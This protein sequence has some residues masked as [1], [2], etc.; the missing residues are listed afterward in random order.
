MAEQDRGAFR[1]PSPWLAALALA[2]TAAAAGALAG[3]LGFVQLL[4]SR[5]LDLRFR[6]RGPVAPPPEILIVGVDEASFET[7]RMRYPF[8]P[9]VYAR[10]VET[11]SRAGA[12]AVAFD[13]LYS[14]PSRECDP[15]GQDALLA[16]SLRKAG[17]VVW[18][19]QL[20]DGGAAQEPIAVIRD[21][22]AGT[23]FINLPDERDSRIRRFQPEKDGRPCFAAAVLEAY[24]GFRPPSATG[25]RLRI[26]NFHGGRSS[27]PTVSMGD[28]LSGKT[29]SERLRGRICL[30][31]ATFAASH[32]LYATPFHSAATSDMPGIEIHANIL[33]GL[34]EGRGLAPDSP[35]PQWAAVAALAFLLAWPV[36]AGRPGLAT[37]AWLGASAGWCLWSLH[38][39]TGAGRVT[40]LA[41][42]LAALAATFGTGVFLSYL[43]EREYRR[44]IRDLFSHYL[45]PRV[46]AWLLRNPGGL[47]LGGQRRLFTVLDTDIEGFTSITER[48]DPALLVAHLNQYFEVLTAAIIEAGGLHDKYVGDA[49]M[50]IFG[51]PLDQPDHAVRALTAARLILERVD[52]LNPVWE[53]QGRPPLRTRIGLCSGW[54]VLGDVGGTTRRTFTA[55]GDAANLASRLEGLNKRFGSRV[56]MSES[57]AK[58]LPRETAMR[59]LGEVVVRGVSKP[60]RVF[61][62]DFGVP[63]EGLLALAEEERR[64]EPRA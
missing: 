6:A 64:G 46:V 21:A 54:V 9:V 47:Q 52:A 61:C 16:D 40:L 55:M 57:T 29:P 23:G 38:R 41:A 32:D 33:A 2:L 12:A 45:D 19:F 5:A 7:L 22:V 44:E 60:V 4:E 10:L 36:F 20:K 28:L 17:N 26:I 51:F 49:V 11:L 43:R 56:L 25:E 8:P 42:P 24:A 50:A 1:G 37:A 35:W 39:F 48:M 14:E 3:K 63:K 15:P 31:G 53:R 59:D 13:F 18:A 62:P 30:V 34:L 27:F 58:L